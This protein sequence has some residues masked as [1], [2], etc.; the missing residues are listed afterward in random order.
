[1]ADFAKRNN[2]ERFILNHVQNNL[3]RRKQFIETMNFYQKIK[4]R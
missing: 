4:S 1:M 3:K 2:S